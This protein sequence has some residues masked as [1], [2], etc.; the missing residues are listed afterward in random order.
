MIKIK[1]Y[2]SG[3]K[4][5]LYLVSNANTNIILECG[6]DFNEIKKMLNRNNLQ[7]NNINACFTS[8]VHQDHSQ[9]ISYLQDYNIPCYATNDTRIKYNLD[10]NNFIP[11]NDNKLYKIN[12]I[13][14]ISLKVNHGSADCYGFIFKDKDNMILFITDFMECKKNLK[15]FKFN[16]IFIECNY[17]EELWNINRNNEENDYEKDNKYKRQINTHQSLNNLIIHLKNMNLSNCD[18]I[19]LIHVSED[20]GNRDLMKNTIEEE[21]GVECVALLH[22]GTEY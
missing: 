16:E 15:P 14:I 1:S 21:F 11:L 2:G 7:F 5:N 10:Y 9:S 17:I 18:K 8:H 22:D 3:S 4:G 13:Q 20:I 12:D 19:T 6:L